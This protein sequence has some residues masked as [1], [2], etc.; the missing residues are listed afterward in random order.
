MRMDRDIAKRIRSIDEEEV[1]EEFW[2]DIPLR[3]DQ[4]LE[5]FNAIYLQLNYPEGR[6]RL[7]KRAAEIELWNQDAFDLA[8]LAV[9]DK[10]AHLKTYGFAQFARNRDK[11]ALQHV[12]SVYLN[13]QLRARKE[14]ERCYNAIRGGSK[15]KPYVGKHAGFKGW[16]KHY[17]GKREK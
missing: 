13:R 2:D 6:E 10:Y 3:D 14:A 15:F 5:Y 8:L 9:R 16:W 11:M 12:R 4:L 17:L 1:T 7:L